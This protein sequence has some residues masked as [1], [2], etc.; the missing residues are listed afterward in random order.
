MKSIIWTFFLL[1]F[2]AS[3]QAQDYDAEL[4]EKLGAD[5]YGMKSYVFVLLKTG[6]NTSTDQAF[7]QECFRSHMENIG[8]LAKEAKLV[9]AGPM[10]KNENQYRGLFILNTASFDEAKKWLEGDKAIAE[11][12]LEPVFYN[13]YGSAALPLYLE[14]A[15]K[16]ARQKP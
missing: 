9:V 3:V 12:L 11:E 6:T 7:I 5:Q 10:G 2:T 16:I 15:E 14:D 4:A 8:K 13:W 1:V